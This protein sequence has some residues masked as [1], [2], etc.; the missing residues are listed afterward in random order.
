MKKEQLRDINNI[1]LIFDR[2]YFT[3]IPDIKHFMWVDFELSIEKLNND[4]NYSDIPFG[5]DSSISMKDYIDKIQ[6]I[7]LEYQKSREEQ[8]DSIHKSRTSLSGGSS[9]NVSYNSITHGEGIQYAM[10]FL[11]LKLQEE[12]MYHKLYTDFKSMV[13]EFGKTHLLLCNAKSNDFILIDYKITCEL[14]YETFANPLLSIIDVTDDTEQISINIM[15]KANERAI[16]VKKRNKNKFKKIIENYEA[17]ERTSMIAMG[18]VI[19]IFFIIVTV[20]LLSL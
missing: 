13:I 14:C 1:L 19:I 18:S 9:I 7:D 2:N 15:K 4:R 3:T 20:G 11:N 10:K 16:E 8:R 17:D 12:Q 5:I 6:E